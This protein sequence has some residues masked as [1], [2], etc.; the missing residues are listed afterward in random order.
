M[1]GLALPVLR[2]G[3]FRLVKFFD[4][5]Q[6]EL[7]LIGVIPLRPFQ[8]D[9][10]VCP[11]RIGAGPPR[12]LRGLAVH[13][14]GVR[15]VLLQHLF[16]PFR[17]GEMPECDPQQR[18]VLERWRVDGRFIC[19]PGHRLEPFSSDLVQPAIARAS[20]VLDAR[21]H[22]AQLL[23]FLELGV[24]LAVGRTAVEEP[25]APVDPLADVVARELV[26]VGQHAE[27]RPAGR[28][29]I[30]LAW[31]SAVLHLSR[32]TTRI[33]IHGVTDRWPG[34]GIAQQTLCDERC[35]AHRLRR[36]FS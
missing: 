30:R 22:Q 16:E 13:L 36:R 10:C 23:Q 27:Q 25:H 4:H 31:R 5:L 17:A 26:L 15:Q 32:L 34:R 7:P 1:A 14:V 20:G 33:A 9:A 28:R 21:G 12:I 29:K 18:T 11:G 19:P 24:D 3:S 2:K 35:L 8:R 6:R